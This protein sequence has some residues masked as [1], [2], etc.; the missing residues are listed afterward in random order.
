VASPVAVASALNDLNKVFSTVKLTPERSR[1][2]GTALESL[3]DEELR[4]AVRSLSRKTLRNSPTPGDLIQEVRPSEPH[5]NAPA[6]RG[7]PDWQPLPEPDQIF[8]STP[9]GDNEYVPPHLKDEAPWFEP[10]ATMV[11]NLA[12]CTAWRNQNGEH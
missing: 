9:E 1:T 6:E 2:W 12:R 11:T 3:T 4:R 10:K 7:I 8:Q 5:T